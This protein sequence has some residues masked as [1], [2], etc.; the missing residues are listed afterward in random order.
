MQTFPSPI[1]EA[2][3][4]HGFFHY[5][6]G[7]HSLTLNIPASQILLAR[8][9]QAGFFV[10]L[11]HPYDSLSCLFYEASC[12]KLIL[13]FL[14]ACWYQPI[15]GDAVAG[16]AWALLT[17]AVSRYSSPH[18]HFPH[19]SPCCGWTGPCVLDYDHQ[20]T[21]KWQSLLSTCPGG[22]KACL[23]PHSK[24]LGRERDGSWANLDLCFALLESVAGFLGFPLTVCW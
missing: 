15:N 5:L 1:Y 6:M 13:Y 7:Y 3:K 16:N 11:T 12:P 2:V 10:L 23:G 17:W 9:L 8:I 20:G 18:R 24:V 14:D 22:Y 19:R 4:S 21:L